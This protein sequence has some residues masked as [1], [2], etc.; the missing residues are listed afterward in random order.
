MKKIFNKSAHLLII[1]LAYLLINQSIFAQAPQKMSYQAVIRNTSGALVSSASVG[2]KIS[3]LQGTATGTAVYTETQNASTNVN[4]LVSLEIGSGTVVLGTFAS[5]NWATGPYFI[6][7]ETDPAGGTNYS[8]TG[9]SQLMSVPYALFS[10]SGTPGPAGPQGPAGPTGPQGPIGLTGA[11][12]TVAGPAGPAGPQG[13]AGTNGTGT[14][15]SGTVAG[16]MNYWNGTAWVTVP[17]ALSLPGNEALTLSFCN[18][19]PTWGPCPAVLP[20]VTTTVVSD[21]TPFYAV[22]GGTIISSGGAEIVNMGV[23]W[24]TSANP[25][26]ADNVTQDWVSSPFTSSMSGLAPNTTY[27][28]RAYATNTV[29]T[30]YGNQVSF[31]TPSFVIAIITTSASDITAVSATSGGS[32]SSSFVISESGVC[33]STS[34]NPTTA[35]YTSYDWNPTSPFTSSISGLAPN[36]TYY[37][38]AFAAASNG[39]TYYGNE[40]SFTTPTLVTTTAVTDIT[41]FSATSGG[42]LSTTQ[43]I[44][45]KGVCWSTSA[46]PTTADNFTQDWGS[47]PFTSSMSGLAPNTTYYVRAFASYNGQTY[48]GNELSFTTEAF[49]ITTTAVTDITAFSAT[50][51]GSLSQY[52]GNQGVCWSTSANP[53]TADNVTQDCCSLPFTSSIYGLALNTTY[54]VRAFASDYN[55][56]TYYGNELSFTTEAIVITTTAVTDIAAFTASSGGSYTIDNATSVGICWGTSTNPT[57]VD[58]SVQGSGS[59]FTS[60]MSGLEQNTSY[61]VRAYATISGVIYYGNQVSFTTQNRLIT[62]TAVSGISGCL[63]TSGGS[64]NFAVASAGICW[65]PSPNPTT[66]DNVTYDQGLPFTSSI[67]GLTPNTTYY[68]RA[69]VTDNIGDTYYGNLISFTTNNLPCIGDSY[70][71]GIVAYV[72]PSGLYGLIAAPSDQGSAEWGCYGTALSGADGWAIGT[73]AQNTLDIMNGCSEAGIAARLCG[74]LI[75]GGY[76]DWYLPSTDELNQLF[77]NSSAVG[78]FNYNYYW[79]SSEY[80]EYDEYEPQYAWYNYNGGQQ[81]AEKNSVLG[82][83]AVRTFTTTTSILPTVTTTAVSAFTGVITGINASSGGTVTSDGNDFIT[84]WGVC[85]STSSNPTTANSFTQ[86]FVDINN[87]SFTSSI[88]GLAPNTTYYVRAYAT[89]SVGTAYGDQLSFTTQLYIGMGYQGGIL[90]YILQAGDPGYNAS[91]SHG[92]IAAPSDQAQAPWGMVGLSVSG[93][94]GEAIGTGAQNTIDII[95]SYG[96][97][98]IAARLCGDLVLGG[99]SDWYLPSKDELNQLFINKVAIGGFAV[100]YYW[101]STENDFSSAWGQNFG[102]GYQFL[103]YK[104]SGNFNVRAVR[105]F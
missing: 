105:A 54:Y 38:R 64:Y 84:A 88:I 28:V 30:A 97:T 75:L 6:K 104:G 82:V 27:Y 18:G 98:S 4:G 40:L 8:I 72:S 68:L 92:I 21:I 93:A 85:W 76:S 70:Q 20:T 45:N 14:F 41:A 11:A 48:Y 90:A 46:N 12:S 58:N 91:V 23:C 49:V 34:S 15:P 69:Y 2:M 3:I 10:A 96:N 99:Y 71:G 43:N 39:P 83:R 9:T 65:G 79:S 29:G 80:D 102:N 25:T 94:D 37:L 73:G 7:T 22:S 26:T 53:T 95:N 66:A 52:I 5:I 55:G 103:N 36:T 78:G 87:Y 47:S 89:N 31:T 33:W 16:E 56:Q 44:G 1:T 51:G 81:L 13:I 86:D 60:S 101:S 35:D 32:F 100:N 67:I 61:Y 42:A 62:T 74:D 24:S 19:V 59:P 63:A 50:S 77:L 57:I 17:P